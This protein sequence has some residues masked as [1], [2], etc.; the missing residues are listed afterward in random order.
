MAPDRA[1]ACDSTASSTSLG[2]SGIGAKRRRRDQTVSPLAEISFTSTAPASTRLSRVTTTVLA[3]VLKWTSSAS[4]YG[5]LAET[6]HDEAPPG[7]LMSRSRFRMSITTKVSSAHWSSRC[8]RRKTGTSRMGS[9]P[10]HPVRSLADS[11]GETT[12]P[13]SSSISSGL[14]LNRRKSTDMGTA[15]VCR[16]LPSAENTSNPL[17]S[18]TWN[19]SSWTRT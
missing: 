4:P 19:P 2:K 18:R 5:C 15:T 3:R 10:D 17:P 7:G 16:W 8:S 12:N 6:D 9:S 13:P 14:S 1:S 11:L